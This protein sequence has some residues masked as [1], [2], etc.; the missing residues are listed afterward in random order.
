[1][2]YPVVF[3]YSGI[4]KSWKNT[5]CHHFILLRKADHLVDSKVLSSILWHYIFW[6]EN[7]GICSLENWES[8]DVFVEHSNGIQHHSMVF[9]NIHHF[10]VKF[11]RKPTNTL[12]WSFMIEPCSSCHSWIWFSD[13][14]MV[15]VKLYLRYHKAQCVALL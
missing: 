6:K 14:V 10:T 3:A 5:L 1:M 4:L 8:K 9:W 11:Y 15:I 7:F 12:Q 2:L 13:V